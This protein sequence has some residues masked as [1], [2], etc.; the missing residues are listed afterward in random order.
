MARFW[1]IAPG[2]E[3]PHPPR[4]DGAATDGHWQQAAPAS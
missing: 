3:K 2:K 1:L 4:R